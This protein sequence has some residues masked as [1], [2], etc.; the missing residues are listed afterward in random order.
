MRKVD[1]IMLATGFVLSGL[2][3]TAFMIYKR[4]E[5]LITYGLKMKSLQVVEASLNRLRMNVFFG[6]TNPSD[7]QIV[8]SKQ[9]Y[10][11][12][13]NGIYLTT[14]QSDVEQIVYP[15]AVS[16]LA[17]A[18]DLDPK[19]VLQKIANST[20]KRLQILTKLKQQ[21][22]K[23]ITKLWVKVGIFNIPITIPYEQT[24]GNWG[25]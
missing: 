8:I 17:V 1:K 19:F 3:L 9:Q 24:I 5:K 21:R 15:R 10:E 16:T 13:I 6:F 11:V 4:A 23:L 2:G 22:I 12:F 18:V 25:Q 14:V 20:A 7:L